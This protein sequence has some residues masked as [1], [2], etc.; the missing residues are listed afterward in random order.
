VRIARWIEIE[1]RIGGRR[2]APAVD[3]R[4]HCSPRRIRFNVGVAHQLQS[5]R[6]SINRRIYVQCR[7]TSGG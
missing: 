1:M 7:I 4:G 5:L 3:L 6:D 2:F